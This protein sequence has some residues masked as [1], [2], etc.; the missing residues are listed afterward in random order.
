[1]IENMDKVAGKMAF[2]KKRPHLERVEQGNRFW[3]ALKNATCN[4]V[5]HTQVHGFF[6]LRASESQGIKR[7]EKYSIIKYRV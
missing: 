2:R 3:L 5:E 7:F 1:M 4:Y 6:Y